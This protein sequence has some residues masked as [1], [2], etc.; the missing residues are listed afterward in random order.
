MVETTKELIDQIDEAAAAIRSHWQGTPAAGIVLG[1]GLGDLAEQ[2][3]AEAAIDYA[4]I[5]HFGTSTALAH[6]GRLVCGKLAGQTVVAMQGRVHLYEGY[7]AAQVALPVYVM[8]RLGASLLILSNASGGMN[9]QYNS[10]EVMIMEDHINLM[11]DN[12]LTGPNDD[13]L[14]PRWPD[15][16]QPYCRQLIEQAE[17]IARQNNFRVHR[18]TYAALSGPSYETRAEYRALRRLGADVVGMSTVPEAIAAVH[19]GL[20]TLALSVVTN[21]ANPDQPVQTDAE[22]V[23]QDAARAANDVQR[24]VLGVLAVEG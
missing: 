3:D 8:Q 7:S 16:S 19:C 15:M 1:T 18:G 5:P 17:E 20:R 13:S 14:G 24:I 23:L 9:P 11:W 6:K 2:I 12:P 22:E 4:D 10:G 21:V